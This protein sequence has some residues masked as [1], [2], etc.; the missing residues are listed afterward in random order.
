MRKRAV[1]LLLCAG[2][3]ACLT[4]C[5]EQPQQPDG[6]SA[7]TRIALSMSSRDQFLVTVEHAVLEHAGERGA[8]CTVWDAGNDYVV[9]MQH[10]KDARTQGYD[11]LIVNAVSPGLTRGILREAGDMPVVFV[12]RQPE[13]HAL[14]AGKQAYV[15]SDDSEPGRFQAAWLNDYAKEQG[16]DSLD[17]V[18]LTGIEGQ[19]S[20]EARR[21]SLIENLR[22]EY[23]FVYDSTAQ[24]D[25]AK[26]QTQVAMLLE[27]GRPFDVIVAQNDE[28][29]IGAAQAMEDAGKAVC[30]IL[31]I[32]GTKAGC[33]A[34]LDGQVAFTVRQSGSE[35]GRVAVDAALALLEGQSLEQ[36]DGVTLEEDGVSLMIPY[37]PVDAENAAQYLDE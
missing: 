29:A 36:I 16:K 3:M 4:G 1:S 20:T 33:Q 28:M 34:V 21:D 12:N 6:Q 7:D 15:G 18:Y 17:L 8:D 26:A 24:F 23:D 13:M 31:G 35:Q 10:V 27:T 37:T 9:Q 25:R 19:A 11:A 2:M 32:D 5:G 30:P 22:V 14:T